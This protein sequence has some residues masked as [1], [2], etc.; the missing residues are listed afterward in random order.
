M[1]DLKPATLRVGNA[2][3]EQLIAKEEAEL[4][5]REDMLHSPRR[6]SVSEAAN[7]FKSLGNANSPLYRSLQVLP[8]L[9]RSSS[10]LHTINSAGASIGGSNTLEL[11]LLKTSRSSS[12]LE[13]ERAPIMATIME[14]PATEPPS[15][16]PSS[17]AAAGSSQ[18]HG[19]AGAS[20]VADSEH[21]LGTEASTENSPVSVHSESHSTLTPLSPDPTR[22][23]GDAPSPAPS[24]SSGSPSSKAEKNVR[25]M[26]ER[27]LSDS[28]MET[29]SS[30]SED[31]QDLEAILKLGDAAEEGKEL[32]TKS[33]RVLEKLL[34]RKHK[35]IRRLVEEKDI[36]KARAEKLEGH[37]KRVMGETAFAELMAAEFPVIEP[38]PAAADP[39]SAD[40]D[41]PKLTLNDIPI[42]ASGNVPVLPRQSSTDKGI[43]TAGG[44]GIKDEGASTFLAEKQQQGEDVQQQRGGGDVKE[45]VKTME[46]AKDVQQTEQPAA[47]GGGNSGGSGLKTSRKDLP[48]GGDEG[49]NNSATGSPTKG[50]ELQQQQ[51]DTTKPIA[52]NEELD[53]SRQAEVAALQVSDEVAKEE[54]IL[55]RMRNDLKVW[56][57]N[58][59]SN[60]F[61]LHLSL[62][63]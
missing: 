52:G 32:G 15:S 26:L 35:E 56:A 8:Q 34:D 21:K 40:A 18:S 3:K 37:L 16:S 60:T 13:R 30:H 11:P 46:G 29:Q 27:M 20:A 22:K 47:S 36:Y 1:E 49:G 10:G 53:E 43:T 31:Q 5:K 7:K 6:K 39:S 14:E 28:A 61:V 4:K 57:H 17:S 50:K 42:S 45:P 59:N 9:E 41:A 24:P 51:Q 25:K 2:K 63:F 23:A 58:T 38:P 54:C 48:T 62:S 12:L 19:S 33:I 44:S 55:F